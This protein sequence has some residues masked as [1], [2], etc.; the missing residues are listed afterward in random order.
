M[1]GGG[2]FCFVFSTRGRGF[3]TEKL[4][5]SGDFEGKNSGP[6]VSPGGW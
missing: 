6:G 5:Q 4:S 3:C 1:P 2:D